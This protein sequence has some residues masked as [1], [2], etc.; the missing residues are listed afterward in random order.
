MKGGSGCFSG[1]A[2]WL[3]FR[4]TTGISI[5]GGLFRSYVSYGCLMGAGGY[6]GEARVAGG[7]TLW[8]SAWSG[9]ACPPFVHQRLSTGRAQRAGRSR[10]DHPHIHG[11]G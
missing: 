7:H 3:G 6:V 2:A 8:S 5:Y 10:S 11:F 9:G 4:A 1:L